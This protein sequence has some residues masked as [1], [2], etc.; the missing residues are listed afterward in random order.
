MSLVSLDTVTDAFNSMVNISSPMTSST[1]DE[2]SHT[3]DA[4]RTHRS[5]EKMRTVASRVWENRETSGSFAECK[6]DDLRTALYLNQRGWHC[7]AVAI[8]VDV[9]IEWELVEAIDRAARRVALDD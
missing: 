5:L 7:G 3:F 8:E 1:V 6:L 4:Y 9:G 2:S